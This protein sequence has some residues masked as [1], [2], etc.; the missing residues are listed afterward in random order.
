MMRL[1]RDSGDGFASI[2]DSALVDLSTSSLQGHEILTHYIVIS[3]SLS[4][5]DRDGLESISVASLDNSSLLVSSV[6]LLLKPVA[7]LVKHVL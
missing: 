3:G 6:M 2:C 4:V 7:L 1:T 5:A